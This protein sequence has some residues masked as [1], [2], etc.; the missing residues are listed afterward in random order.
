MPRT[1][2]SAQEFLDR[3]AKPAPTCVK[4]GV[5]DKNRMPAPKLHEPTPED[6]FAARWARVFPDLPLVREHPFI[7]DRKFRADFAH[8]ES[9][10]AIEYQGGIWQ[11]ERTGHSSGKG[12]ERDC[13]KSCLAQL[14]GWAIFPLSPAMSEQAAML[15]CIASFMRDRA[16]NQAKES[17]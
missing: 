8:L 4:N 10:V 15:H 9:R 1:T 16:R 2:I 12:I 3:Y 6:L 11:R 17:E 13:L 7:A 5:A 14:G